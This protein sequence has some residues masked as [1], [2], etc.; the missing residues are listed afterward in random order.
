MHTHTMSRLLDSLN[1]EFRRLGATAG[2]MMSVLR[3]IIGTYLI[4]QHMGILGDVT[5]HVVLPGLAITF[6]F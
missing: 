1:F 5:P 3:P 2:V 6:S 4:V